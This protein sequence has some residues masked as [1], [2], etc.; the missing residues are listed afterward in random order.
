[1]SKEG[2]RP[3]RNLLI[4]HVVR[5]GNEGR[6]AIRSDCTVQCEVLWTL[7][8]DLLTETKE[9]VSQPSL[10]LHVVY[11]SKVVLVYLQLEED[12]FQ[13]SAVL[14]VLIYGMV[15]LENLAVFDSEQVYKQI[16]VYTPLLLLVL[17]FLFAKQLL[18]ELLLLFLYQLILRSRRVFK[19]VRTQFVSVD[20]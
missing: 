8:Y 12:A 4:L 18:E 7:S 15:L 13:Y 16:D 14:V 19:L 10:V 17:L 9:T 11:D 3:V 6:G 5:V 1:M 2:R 20:L